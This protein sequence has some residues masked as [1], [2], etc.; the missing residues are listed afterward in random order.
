MSDTTDHASIGGGSS[1]AGG[2]TLAAAAG[3]TTGGA[4]QPGG[5]GTVSGGARTALDG[6]TVTGATNTTAAWRDDWRQAFATVDG[7]VDP[8]LLRQVE[9]YDSPEAF[10]RA[11]FSLRTRMD[12]GDYTTKLPAN[13][14]PDEVTAWRAQN[15]IPATAADY[16]KTLPDSVKIP[17]AQKG[18]INKF[19]EALHG[20]NAP[21]GTANAALDAYYKIVADNQATLSEKNEATKTATVDALNVAWGAEYRGNMN[22]VKGL[23]DSMPNG[24]GAALLDA[25]MADGTMLLSHEGPMRALAAL[26]REINPAA[27]VIPGAGAAAG[28]GI[29]DRISEIEGIMKTDPNKYYKGTSG[30]KLQSEYRTL[31]DAQLRT[32]QRGG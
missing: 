16:L 11:H 20:Q 30:E 7:V 3:A 17:E 10:A 26:A 19:L 24:A 12:G 13:A 27:S 22:A 2:A 32:Q 28:K 25:R 9:R 6:G 1:V 5:S 4:T 29:E 14:T 18:D 21:P 23:L 15:G 8:K 31:L